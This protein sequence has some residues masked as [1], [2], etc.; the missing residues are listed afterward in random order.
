MFRIAVSEFEKWK[1]L[2]LSQNVKLGENKIKEE[3]IYLLL[4]KEKIETPNINF[5]TLLPVL[6]HAGPAFLKNNIAYS[7]KYT[8]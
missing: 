2:F 4:N 5:V 6:S 3:N 8:G 7:L 1:T